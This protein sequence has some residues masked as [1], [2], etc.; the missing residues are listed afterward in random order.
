MIITAE[1]PPEIREKLIAEVNANFAI[2]GME[3]DES[4]K[5]IQQE[6]IEGKASVEDLLRHALEF[7]VSAGKGEG[8]EQ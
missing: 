4:D 8:G 5:R 7:A 6:F 1:T 2:E 3:P